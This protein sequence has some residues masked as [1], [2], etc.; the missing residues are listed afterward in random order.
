MMILWTSIMESI[1]ERNTLIGGSKLYPR[2]T[3]RKSG[4]FFFFEDL[5]V[6]LTQ[7]FVIFLNSEYSDKVLY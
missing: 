1:E 6:W 5:R 2:D 4:I 7:E 3:S